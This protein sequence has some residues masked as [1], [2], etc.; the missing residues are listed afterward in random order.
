VFDYGTFDQTTFDEGP[1]PTVIVEINFA[2]RQMAVLA[3]PP[4]ML[5]RQNAALDLPALVTGPP[6]VNF[7]G[8]TAP[9]VARLLPGL[10]QNIAADTSAL[11]T[12]PETNVHFIGKFLPTVHRL[13]QRLRE[14]QAS[15]ASFLPTQPATNINF[16]GRFS[17]PVMRLLRLAR[18]NPA[19]D[20]TFLPTQTETDPHWPAKPIRPAITL[21]RAL[22]ENPATDV[23]PVANPHFVPRSVVSVLK[24]LA[25][26][27]QNAAAD[28]P[29]VLS[30]DDP[31]SFIGKTAPTIVRLLPWLR[32][33]AG[34]DLPGKADTPANFIGRLIPGT[35]NLLATL[36]QNSATDIFRLLFLNPNYIATGRPRYTV[37]AGDQRQTIAAGLAREVVAVGQQRETIAAGKPRH[38]VIVGISN[39]VAQTNDLQPPID[40]VVEEETVTFDYGLIL[41][42]TASITAVVSMTCAISQ[43]TSDEITDPTPQNR[44][45]GPS[46]IATSPNSGL[47]NQAVSQLVGTMIGGI[48]Y[49]LECVVTTSD[50]QTLSLWTHITCQTPS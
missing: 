20:A 8:R 28:V 1:I 35:L 22:R 31:P 23:P 3:V 50:G 19:S 47:P 11:P 14:N 41:A 16:I 25:G 27:R 6:S 45:I 37:A 29:P 39:N 2:A 24:L 36:R 15:D 40:A 7:I 12:Q 46:F 4:L 13:F 43:S 18:E 10:R 48:V 42:A 38:L 32:Q 17:A 44:I 30:A 21:L 33:N 26:L 5:Y 34:G 49:I 9:T